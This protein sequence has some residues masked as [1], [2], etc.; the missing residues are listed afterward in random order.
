MTEVHETVAAKN[1]IDLRQAISDEIDMAKLDP[2]AT[3]GILVPL[4]QYPHNIGTDVVD[5][6][7][8]DGPHPM[9]VATRDIQHGVHV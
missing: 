1:E 7:E 3:M 6:V 9:E 2:S 5:P 8:V 4:H